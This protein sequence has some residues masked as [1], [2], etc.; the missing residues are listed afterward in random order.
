M[1]DTPNNPDESIV[2]QG[3]REHNLKDISVEIPRQQFVVITGVSGSGKSTL[4]FDI[5]FA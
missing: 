4:A 5:L 3:A 2:I 1:A